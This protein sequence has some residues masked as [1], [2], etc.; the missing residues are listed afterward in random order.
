MRS[1]LRHRE[2]AMMGVMKIY[3]QLLK[4]HGPQGWW[5]VRI[6]DF[7]LQI[8]DRKREEYGLTY[9]VPYAKLESLR[10]DFRD[11]YFEIAVGAILTQNTTWRNV[12]GS[13]INLYDEKALTPERLLKLHP[14]CLQKIIRPAGYF[15]Q[16]TKKLRFFAQWLVDKHHGDVALLKRY[17]I[18]DTRN[19]LLNIWGIGNET[20]DS[21]MLYALNK[22]I[23]VVDEYTRRLCREHGVE[24]KGY[25]EY[26]SHFESQLDADP[27][28]FREY[29]ALIVAWG[30][31]T[32]TGH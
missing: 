11:P 19:K 28:L 2:A 22:P 16:K 15:R 3:Q 13:I 30:K 31:N 9:G 23:F 6:A 25:D 8:S 12:A 10:T 1:A 21:I 17:S 29:H 24:R 32:I 27:E 4:Q 26:R 7:R 14:M 5:P 20:A 18:L